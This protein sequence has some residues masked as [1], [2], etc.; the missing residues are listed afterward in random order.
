MKKKKKKEEAEL[1]IGGLKKE[2]RGKH[3]NS[4]TT[5]EEGVEFDFAF[6]DELRSVFVLQ[7]WLNIRPKSIFHPG[8][9]HPY[10]FLKW[11]SHDSK[12]KGGTRG[13][14]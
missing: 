14:N 4:R 12:G 6:A 8:P 1:G 3:L 2:R 10:T 9:P 11:R 5:F 13:G 7:M